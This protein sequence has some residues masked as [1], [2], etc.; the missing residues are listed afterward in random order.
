MERFGRSR[1]GK[2]VRHIGPGLL[3]ASLVTLAALVALGADARA[4]SPAVV[5]IRDSRY[6]PPTIT[7]EAGTTIRWINHDEETHTITSDTGAFSSAGLGLD[8]DYTHTF[9]T[10]GEYPYTCDLHPFM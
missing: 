5:D 1:V 10:R 6:L 9:T 7:V 8:E 3:A 4:V 2:G